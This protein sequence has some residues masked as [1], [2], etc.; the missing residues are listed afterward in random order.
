MSAYALFQ[1]EW[2]DPAARTE[3]TQGLSGMVEKYGGRFLVASSDLKVIEGKWDTRRLIIAEFPS[4][5][6]LT[7]WYESEEYRPLL[8]LRLKNA[9]CDAI[10]VEGTGPSH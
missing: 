3:Y 6:Q 5:K 8:Q 4:M 1:V 10:V 2:T 7:E 9:S